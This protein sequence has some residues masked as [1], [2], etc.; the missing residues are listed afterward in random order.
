MNTSKARRLVSLM[1]QDVHA[2]LAAA[3]DRYMYFAGVYTDRPAV[4]HIAQDRLAFPQLL[5]FTEDGLPSLSDERRTEFMC[6]VTGLP[7][8]WCAAWEEVQV[9]NVHS[10]DFFGKQA[11]RQ[12]SAILEAL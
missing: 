8:E 7:R 11:R 2:T 9:V 4:D 1:P 3:H 5:R 10:E 6:A 12:A